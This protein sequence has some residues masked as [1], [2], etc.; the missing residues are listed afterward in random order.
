MV[1][2][3]RHGHSKVRGPWHYVKVLYGDFGI[4]ELKT[5]QYVST[6]YFVEFVQKFYTENYL[7]NQLHL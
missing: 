7:D 1:F 2:K 6:N 5:E 3:R 4:A